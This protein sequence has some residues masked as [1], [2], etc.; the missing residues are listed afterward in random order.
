[1]D[2]DRYS[3]VSNGVSG[4][5]GAGPAGRQ[6]QLDTAYAHKLQDAHQARLMAL[7]DARV[8]EP[9]PGP[10][11]AAS[12]STTNGSI[13]S[14]PP[15][16]GEPSSF[17]IIEKPEAP[18]EP[19]SVPPPDEP[20][21][22][23]GIDPSQPPHPPECGIYYY[24]VTITYGKRDDTTIGVGFSTK[25]VN[26]SRPPGWEPES[27]GYHGDDGK[28]F[29]NNNSGKV[30]GPKFTA[31]DVVGCGVNFNAGYIFFTRNGDNLGAAFQ[32]V[33]GKL[34]PSVGLK[35]Y[36]E[37]VRVNFGQIPFVFDIDGMM[38]REKRRI[39]DE[40]WKTSP[41]SL[42]IRIG[43]EPVTMNETDL[44]QSLVLQFLQHDGYVETAR[45]FAEEIEAE[46]QALAIGNQTVGPINVRDDQDATNRQRIRRAILE[47]DIDR[48][49]D[50]IDSCYPNVLEEDDFVHLRLKCRRFI[51]MVRRSAEMRLHYEGKR[52]N[53]ADGLQA[54]ELDSNGV[55]NGN[56]ESMDTEDS[57]LREQVEQLEQEMLEYGQELQAEYRNDP[58]KEI[59]KT[60]E[61]IWSLMAYPNPLGEPKVAHLM[62][63]KNRATTAEMVNSRILL[64]L[65]KSSSADLT[66]LYEDTSDLVRDLREGWTGCLF[67]H[68]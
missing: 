66:K 11:L 34:Y 62:D 29:N 50:L 38:A 16:Q 43:G 12:T 51:E 18:E 59:G 22:G 9:Q 57:D 17:D 3:S 26:L 5:Q 24:E 31:G 20:R 48:A 40:I 56:W 28:C 32:D 36:G 14:K 65:G 67:L 54:M 47:G 33:K 27:W 49:L 68:A 61:D 64:S 1:M 52:S 8:Q 46:R 39:H 15:P 13:H 4:R 2:N 37:H 35:K 53:G 45:A 44:I 41:S 25:H 30:Y 19:G 21:P 7:R 42:E 23:D 10:A 60:L 6:A 63:N 58:R 55:E